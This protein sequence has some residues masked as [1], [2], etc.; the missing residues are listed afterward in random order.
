ML[1]PSKLK[2]LFISIR[3]VC[4]Q[5]M[6]LSAKYWKL[7]FGNESVFVS[8]HLAIVFAGAVA[9]ASFSL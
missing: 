9:F 5:K 7:S 6:L 3:I 4:P 2:L 1:T 8:T